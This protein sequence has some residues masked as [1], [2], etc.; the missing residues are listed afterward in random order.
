M[1]LVTVVL[2]TKD[3]MVLSDG[4]AISSSHDSDCCEDHWLDFA[5]TSKDGE[6]IGLTLDLDGQWFREVPG[7]GIELVPAVPDRHPIRVPGYGSNNGYYGSNIDLL[8]TSPDGK[9]Q[10]WD[11]SECQDDWSGE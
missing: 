8:L 3:K 4:S 10:T 1:K 9:V 7:Y 11:V 6:A 5:E 2:V